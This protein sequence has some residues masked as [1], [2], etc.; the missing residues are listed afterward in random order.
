MIII[1][2]EDPKIL[3]LS[4]KP[5]TGS[6]N[7]DRKNINYFIDYHNYLPPKIETIEK[8]TPDL[9]SDCNTVKR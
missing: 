6:Y 7:C 2:Q 3:H 9:Q 4:L 8:L 1:K 5:L